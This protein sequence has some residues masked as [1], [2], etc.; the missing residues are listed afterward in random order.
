MCTKISG[1]SDQDVS[2][3]PGPAFKCKFQRLITWLNTVKCPTIKIWVLQDHQTVFVNKFPNCFDQPAWFSSPWLNHNRYTRII[4]IP[5]FQAFWY[6]EKIFPLLLPG[7]VTMVYTTP[8]LVLLARTVSYTSQATPLSQRS[9]RFLDS[10]RTLSSKTYIGV[11]TSAALQ[12]YRFWTIF[13][14][15]DWHA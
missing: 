11:N 14:F 15:S 7:A 10:K 4:G 13:V 6:T 5:R 9:D 1:R 12:S 2:N 8:G 3:S